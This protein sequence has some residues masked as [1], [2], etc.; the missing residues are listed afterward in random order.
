M[1]DLQPKEFTTVVK[2]GAGL[3]TRASEDDIDPSECADGKNFDLDPQDKQ[4]RNRKPFDLIGT[5]PNAS[6]IRGG[7]CL[8]KS[9][10]TV[11][12]LV[13][14]GNTVYEWDGATT[15]TSKGTVSATAKLRGRLEHN[16][17]LSDKVIITD[18][19]LQQPVMEWDGTTLQNVTFTN[20]TGSTSFGT[21]KSRYCIVSNERVI[22]ANIDDNGTAYPH[23]IIGAQRSDYTIITVNQR[24]SSSL[25]EADPFFLIQPDFR[26]INGMVEAFGIVATSS[27]KGSMY[28][29]T[30]ASAKDFAFEELYPRSGAS[31][32]EG[33]TYVGNDIF[34]GRQGRIESLVSTDKFGDVDTDDLSDDIYD[35]IQSY[36]NWTIVYNSRNKRVYCFPNESQAW[37]YHKSLKPLDVSPWSKWVTANSFA[38]NPTFVMNMLDPNDGLEYVFMGDSSGNF[39]RLEGSGTSGD[40]GSNS[41]SAER[42]S[43]LIELPDDT[44]AWNVEGWISYRTGDP[45]TVTI[46]L[47]YRG[48][49]IFNESVTIDIPTV[50][51]RAVYNGSY[52]Y[53]NGTGYGSFSGRLARQPIAV[54]GK[55]NEAQVRVTVED[56]VDFA[57]KEVGFRF[58]QARP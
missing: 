30:G 42:L 38:F 46:S 41:I 51:N 57:I 10:G 54:A 27:K 50:S 19:N 44:Q 23:L 34:Y 31:G 29:L 8:L 53:S 21:F 13:Q 28:K 11:S 37:V 22:F 58:N 20:E 2:F 5:V 47:E 3:H 55:G 36:D 12:V 24:P 52:Y 9:D 4:F 39:Y 16:W 35:Q 32:D 6:E 49:T 18:L 1:A 17:Q 14:A 45:C 56:T 33:V 48:K 15:F 7:A 25:S 40:A 26:Y 43:G